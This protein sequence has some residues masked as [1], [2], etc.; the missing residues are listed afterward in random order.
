MNE[1]LHIHNYE[2]SQHDLNPIKIQLKLIKMFIS[3]LNDSTSHL[4]YFKSEG[5]MAV[6]TINNAFIPNT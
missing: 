4:N 5:K 1:L 6:S 3:S 2:R